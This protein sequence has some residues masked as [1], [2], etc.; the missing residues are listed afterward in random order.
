M[1]EADCVLERAVATVVE[2]DALDLC[3]SVL[4][5]A[6]EAVDVHKAAYA[7]HIPAAYA[8]HRGQ[9]WLWQDACSVCRIVASHDPRC[10][11]TG[12]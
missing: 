4:I 7:A 1:L 8:T 2:N 9:H 12:E 5:L 11:K 10:R 6:I 3:L